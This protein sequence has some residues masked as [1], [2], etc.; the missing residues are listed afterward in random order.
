MSVLGKSA[1]ALA[2]AALM[3][4][5]AGASNRPTDLAGGTALKITNASLS[6]LAGFED[7]CGGVSVT[8]N[9]T[10]TGATN[11]GGGLDNFVVELW[12]D[13]VRKANTHFSVPVGTTQTFSFSFTVPGKVGTSAPGVG[14]YV[15]EVDNGSGVTAV[16]PFFPTP[17]SGCV[18]GQAL[19]VPTMSTGGLVALAGMLAALAGWLGFG[20]RKS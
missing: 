10:V 15:P 12:D 3:M 18:I 20:R 7:S 2:I 8:G 19:N 14:I 4:S 9:V 17:I 13:Q 6:N 1:T 11:D 16:D 5:S